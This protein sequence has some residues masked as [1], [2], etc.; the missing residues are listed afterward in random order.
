M[1]L[2]RLAAVARQLERGG[3]KGR[4]MRGRKRERVCVRVRAK[5]TDNERETEKKKTER[6]RDN[7]RN[8]G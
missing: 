2:D 5:E 4:E 3:E 6:E 7:W 8:V 1:R